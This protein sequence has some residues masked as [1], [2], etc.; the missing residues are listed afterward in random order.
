[1]KSE[2]RMSAISASVH[3]FFLAIFSAKCKLVTT[4]RGLQMGSGGAGAVPGASGGGERV[5][6][7]R[8]PTP[9]IVDLLL[10]RLHGQAD[11]KEELQ[12]KNCQVRVAQPASDAHITNYGRSGPSAKECWRRKWRRW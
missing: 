12:A 3:F 10:V 2:S 9:A 5:P 11:A 8:D 4:S 6:S 7:S 1:M